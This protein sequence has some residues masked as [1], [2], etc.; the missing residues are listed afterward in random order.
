MEAAMAAVVQ[1]EPVTPRG[2]PES[3]SNGFP[4]RQTGRAG[5]GTGSGTGVARAAIRTAAAHR[6]KTGEAAAQYVGQ[7]AGRQA[8]G[9]PAGGRAASR[10]ATAAKPWYETATDGRL[11]PGLRHCGSLEAVLHRDWAPGDQ[12]TSEVVTAIRRLAELPQ[13]IKDKLA[14]GLDA[15]YVGAGGVP[16]LDDMGRLK[17]V[18]LP[19]GHATWDVCAGAYG[20]GKIV[21]GSR[22]S[23]TPDVTCHEVGHALDDIDGPDGKWQSDSEVFRGLYERCEE[24]MAGELR[25]HAGEAGRREFFADA[26][27]AI[28]SGQ[29][30]AL[31]D[32]LGGDARAALDVMLYFN[33]RYGI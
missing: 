4:R 20:H 10:T 31:L 32:M 28:A 22:P 29:R 16:D 24:R 15:I 19:S 27:A 3:G 11:D 2:R 21:I 14:A 1:A 30:P 23:P 26:F 18:P 33:V 5:T 6:S 17:G 13:L 7:P 12:L 8:P 25:G 9:K